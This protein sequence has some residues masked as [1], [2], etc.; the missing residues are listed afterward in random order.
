MNLSKMHFFM[1]DD[2]FYSAILH[3]KSGIVLLYSLETTLSKAKFSTTELKMEYHFRLALKAVLN[4]AEVSAIHNSSGIA[5][6][7]GINGH[8]EKD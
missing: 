2:K 3:N 5:P 6:S 7:V 8:F 4:K 1:T